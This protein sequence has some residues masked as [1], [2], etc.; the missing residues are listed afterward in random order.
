MGLWWFWHSFHLGTR[1]HDEMEIFCR[2]SNIV[3]SS[4]VFVKTIE[5]LNSCCLGGSPPYNV[6]DCQG[7]RSVRIISTWG[8]AKFL[9]LFGMWTL[10]KVLFLNTS[11]TTQGGGGSF[12]DR[13]PI[14]EVVCCESRMA[15]RTHWW[16]ERWLDLCFLEWLQ[17]LQWSPHHNCWM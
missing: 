9:F 6:L 10:S 2:A 7:L 5:K 14:G 13:K 15:E 12:K 3:T 1:K 17:W 4:M 11:S 16:T 8:D